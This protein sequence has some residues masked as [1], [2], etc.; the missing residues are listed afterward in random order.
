MRI[1]LQTRLVALC[2]LIV[3]AAMLVV[4]LVSFTNSRSHTLQLITSQATQLAQA[5][6]ATLG[7][8]LSSKQ[9]MVSALKPYAQSEQLMEQLQLASRG[10]QF[11]QTF[12]GFPDR[13]AIFSEQRQRPADYD[14][15]TRTWYRGAVAAGGAFVSAPYIG[16]ST[17]K[18]L[19]TFAD[20]VGSAQLPQAVVAGDVMM[21]DVLAAIRAIQPTPHSY[22]FLVA[23]DGHIIA[24]QD[25]SLTLQPL[26]KLHADLNIERLQN[27]G[28]VWDLNGRE[29]LLFSQAVPG[30]QWHLAV[31]MDREEARA[32][33]NAMAWTSVLST[34]LA[35][36]VAAGLLLW[37]IRSALLRL[38]DVRTAI[39]AAGDGN[40]SQ[41]LAQEGNDELTDI[42]R[43]Y[44]RF[45]DNIAQ[46]LHRLRDTSGSVEVAASEIAAGNQNLSER[47]EHQA[48]ALAQTVVSI[49][50]LTQNV[51][52]NAEH[53]GSA[54]QLA[55]SAY[56]VATKGG[57]VVAGVVDMMEDINQSS[58]KIADII[59]VIDGIAFQTNILALNA[60]V[61]AARAGEQGRGFA[62]VAGEVRQLAQRSATAAREISGLINDS[63][64][65]VSTGSALV[66]QA[67]QTMQEIVDSVQRVSH[68]MEDISAATRAQSQE[69][70][71]INHAV[72]DMEGNTQQNTALV[73]EAAAAADSL[74]DQAV[75]LAHM[76][77]SFTL[78]PA[79]GPALHAVEWERKAGALPAL[80][81]H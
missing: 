13:R 52:R 25:A 50:N 71:Q 17:G 74:R 15:T 11:D 75:K 68:I 65:K 5:H 21:E 44:N 4:G 16:A 51:Q 10:G 67:G 64:S 72:V 54:N 41:R 29:G 47:T 39:A 8:W 69:I 28:R 61:E 60:A 59:G 58:R 24:H 9:Q 46:V 76:V 26:S 1:S 2:V 81:Q 56:Q 66:Y 40:F 73:E 23:G 48:E 33:L 43:A 80:A 42:A 36:V 22:A 55:R 49:D 32:A 12:V 20:L 30:T 3:A 19:I 7:Q 6:A 62:V 77:G 34:L 53:A 79:D 37:A 14:P 18:M 63:V 45:A 31:V 57:E 35:C 78:R 70:A 38:A 27:A